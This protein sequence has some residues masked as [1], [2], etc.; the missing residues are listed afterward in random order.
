[1]KCNFDKEFVLA[2]VEG[3]VNCF[4]YVRLSMGTVSRNDVTSVSGKVNNL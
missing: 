3:S 1:M 4:F 2:G